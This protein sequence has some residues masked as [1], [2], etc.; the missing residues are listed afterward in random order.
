MRRASLV[1]CLL[2]AACS[3]AVELRVGPVVAVPPAAGEC[4]GAVEVTVTNAGSQTVG[5]GRLGVLL[6]DERSDVD[7]P[8]GPP[9]P[10]LVTIE[11]PWAGEVP[12]EPGASRVLTKTVVRTLAEP[13]A[14]FDA[15][16]HV[17]S[18]DE[19]GARTEWTSPAV[20][21][22]PGAWPVAEPLT[23]DAIDRAVA[24]GR[25]V[26][27]AFCEIGTPSMGVRMLEVRPDGTTH[28]VA[29]G[30]FGTA[31]GDPIVGAGKMSAAQLASFVAAV[32]AAPLDAFRADPGA[33]NA[34]DGDRVRLLVAA[35]RSACV[36]SSVDEDFRAA[37]L[38]PFIAQLRALIAALP[39]R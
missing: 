29:A 27:V 10:A 35:G 15:S 17:P 19:K 8:V 26:R 28:G 1:L 7:P 33:R 3:S 5:L 39:R 9:G 18:F 25:G 37:G 24:E 16:A 36:L 21:F 31:N 6:P 20:P 30:R 13:S 12:L 38:E 23:K 34:V 2:A 14:P 11:P 4:V 32:R 22:D